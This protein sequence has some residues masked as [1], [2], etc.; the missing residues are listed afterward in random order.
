MRKG[1]AVLALAFLL[2]LFPSIALAQTSTITWTNV[3]QTID[4]FGASTAFESLNSS[5]AMQFFSPTSGLGFSLLRVQVPGSPAGICSTV[6][7]SCA[8]DI[9]TIN[10]AK[11][12]GA[13]VWA[14][15]WSPPAAMKSNG[16]TICNNGSGDGILNAGSYGAYA[17]WLSNYIKS[18]ASQ[19]T[20]LYALSV[21]NEPTFCPTTYDGAIWSDTNLDTFIKTNL[22]PT[23]ASQGQSGVRIIMPESSDYSNLNSVA[24]T[25]MADSGCYNFL[26]INAWHDYD[27]TYNPPNAASNP[28]SSLGKGYWE[29]EASAG[30]GFGPSLCGGCWDP[31]MADGLLWAS[32]IDDRMAVRNANSW[33]FWW[34]IGL[35]NDNEGLTNPAVGATD[36]KR[37]YVLGQYS[38]FVR[39]GW[40]RIDATHAPTSGVTVSAY[41][42][43]TGNNFAIVATNQNSSPSTVTFNMSGFSTTSVSPWVTSAS[44]SLT[45]QPNIAVSGTS[46]TTTL[47]ANSVTSFVGVAGG[48]GGSC[49]AGGGT[50]WLNVLD[51]CRGMNWSQ[52]GIP[53]GLPDGS[54]TQCGSTIT[55]TGGDDTTNIQNAVNACTVN[56]FVNVSAGTF[57]STGTQFPK[58]TTGH[59]VL[60]G[61]GA[62]ST[63]INYTAGINCNGASA[64]ICISSSDGTFPGGSTTTTTWTAGFSKGATQITLGSV[65]GIVVNQT[66]LVLNQCDTGYSTPSCTGAAT[67]NNGYFVCSTPWT[68]PGV[69][70]NVPGFS[71]DG[72]TWR[73]NAWQMETVM[74]TA[75]NPGGCGATCVNISQPLVHPNWSSGQSPQ[76][77]LIQPVPL[78]GVE[79][80]AL[81]GSGAGTTDAC[82]NGQ[83]TW[84][85][86]ISG[87]KCSNAYSRGFY[88]LDSFHMLIQNNYVTHAGTYGDGMGIRISWGG[89]D[90]IQNNICQQW[91]V[92]FVNDGPSPGDV[93]AYNYF[94]DQFA[95]SNPGNGDFMWSGDFIHS[96][97][98]DF[99][100]FEGNEYNGSQD[101]NVHGGHL[102]Q[103]RFRNF[104]WGWESCANGQC[105]AFTA[106]TT[107]TTGIIS[108]FASRY[109][110]NVGNVL[111]TPGYSGIYLNSTPFGSTQIYQLGGGNN[112]TMPPEPPD[113]LVI[114]TGMRWATYD[115]VT[116]AIRF[117]GNSGDTGWSMNCAGT[118]E[119]PT[120]APT[121]PNPIPSVGDT[122]IGQPPLPNSFYLSAKPAWFGSKTWPPIGPDRTGG[123]VGQCSG[124]LNAAGK[125][126]GLAATSS[127]QCAGSSLN[128][129]AWAGHV[130]AN[131]AMA[132]F[133]SMGGVP[134]GTGPVLA[135]DPT[136]CYP[137]GGGGSPTFSITPATPFNYGS[138]I[139]GT[140]VAQTFTV[141]NPG[142]APLAITL[143][144]NTSGTNAADFPITNNNC[145][146]A[147][148]GIIAAGGSCTIE[149][150]FTPSLVGAESASLILTHNATGSPYTL[151]L[152]GTGTM[153]PPPPPVI[154][155]PNPPTG[156][157][158]V[159][160]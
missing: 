72:N 3:H 139:V 9:A 118:S 134:D 27:A 104:Y 127:A 95:Q 122:G 33:Q 150:T 11:A 38:K 99:Q 144:Y 82:I 94:I 44:L 41:K 92:C 115:S 18:L 52:A 105:D 6:N 40:V 64:A 74:V 109:G 97:G 114:S 157:V 54:W 13:K 78:D 19:G 25:C 56:H 69:G 103:T 129:A 63:F 98:D 110:A 83:N 29:T 153:T 137:T 21:Q 62:N 75:I 57:H 26:G 84:M 158:G 86:F 42:E 66:I 145:A 45:Q 126:N 130:N 70:C 53:G 151:S 50:L 58:N 51:P 141:S 4:G 106:K 65:A 91:K 107:S 77:V 102:N 81:D 68:S 8:G 79:N 34:I 120:A 73:P 60:R 61:Q 112:G 16:D 132:C 87:V 117:C 160:F 37:M 90:L 15:P 148:S 31:S 113:P 100:L 136:P 20:T 17:T 30:P 121:Y 152:A 47:A 2:A 143:P 125:F 131:P 108:S 96:T 71:P 55:P 128:A 116:G 49:S 59:I 124:T 101:D 12:L 155:R 93:I 80:L 28:Y 35:N 1:L 36:S 7:T 43:P 67:D 88:F 48:G 111:G 24:D 156:L 123:N 5:Q 135:F 119:I 14:A 46:F 154:T 10:L 140:P 133:F 22:G 23:M 32:I 138:L 142:T 39:P 147:F 76:A 89:D 146:S 159:P 149:I 85:A